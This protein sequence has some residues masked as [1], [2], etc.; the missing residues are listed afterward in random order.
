[1]LR[2]RLLNVQEASLSGCNE[3]LHLHATHYTTWDSNLTIGLSV[4]ASR[5]LEGTGA[6]AQ[7]RHFTSQTGQTHFESIRAVLGLGRNGG[8]IVLPYVDFSATK[9]CMRPLRG[10]L[11][12][13]WP[14]N[15]V[16]LAA[17]LTGGASVT[18]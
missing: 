9:D 2:Q 8:Q 18:R 5:Q 4:T 15:I 11:E 16:S 12:R 6:D 7:E 1:M 3:H 13:R 17:P 14:P 10:Q